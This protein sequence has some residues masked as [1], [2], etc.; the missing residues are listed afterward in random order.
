MVPEICQMHHDHDHDHVVDENG[1]W[2][3]SMH[4]QI[5]Q[6]EPG[7]CPICGMDLIPAESSTGADHGPLVYE[8]TPE[9]VAL[10]NVHTSVVNLAS[11]EKR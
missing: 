5:R 8:M 1:E 6:D 3:C 7:D 2:T 10:A 4:P 9:A 11:A